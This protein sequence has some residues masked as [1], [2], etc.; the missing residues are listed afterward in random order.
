LAG[1]RLMLVPVL[2]IQLEEL[3][4]EPSDNVQENPAATL[5]KGCFWGYLVAEPSPMQTLP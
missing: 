3:I 1:K 5:W 2:A 4:H